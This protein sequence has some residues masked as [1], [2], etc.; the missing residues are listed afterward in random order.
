[1]LFFIWKS[2]WGF[3]HGCYYKV[4]HTFYCITYVNSWC[5]ISYYILN[6]RNKEIPMGHSRQREINNNWQTPENNKDKTK[7]THTQHQK[8]KTN[9][10]HGPHQ[11]TGGRLRC[12]GRV[13]SLCFLQDTRHVKWSGAVLFTYLN[14]KVPLWYSILF[15]I[16]S[17][18]NLW[19]KFQDWLKDICSRF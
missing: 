1:M 11:K 14:V 12:S 17:Q 13:S 4:Y 10:Q 5:N 9:E 18:T 8:L 3:Q 2:K 15:W 19:W 16:V 7:T 6:K